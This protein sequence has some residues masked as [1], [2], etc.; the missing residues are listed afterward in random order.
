MRLDGDRV[1]RHLWACLRAYPSRP[2]AEWGGA[3]PGLW[4]RAV[5]QGVAFLLARQLDLRGDAYPRAEAQGQIARALRSR[6]VVTEVLA[7][8][9]GRQIRCAPLKGPLLAERL[10]DDFT[11]RPTTDVDVLVGT[12]DL[13]HAMVA[14]QAAGAR[15]EQPASY[16]YHR[17]NHHHVSAELHGVPVEV[18][19]RASS[20]F[21][22]VIPAEPLLD[23]AAPAVVD[24]ASILLLDPMDELVYLAVNA[25]THRFRAVLL[26]DLKRLVERAAVDW[27]VAERRARQWHVARATAAA[28]VLAGRRA[29]L[30]LAGVPATWLEQG[31]RALR[32]LPE[33]PLRAESY[34]Q[35]RRREYGLQSILADSRARAGRTLLHHALHALRRRVHRTWPSLAPWHWSG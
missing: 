31:E 24:G 1:D 35:K 17:H 20:T 23:R 18:H 9:T 7:L 5:E 29:G 25:A 21:G 33:L 22:S 12:S 13:D 3:I 16:R 4:D 30:D 8:F 28:L 11:L 6:A 32:L 19:F 14:L 2:E 10:Y 26:L 34:L 27:I 15:L